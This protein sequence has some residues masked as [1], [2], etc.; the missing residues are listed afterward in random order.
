MDGNNVLT[1]GPGRVT[2]HK[3]YVQG[4]DNQVLTLNN[5]IE[6]AKI[7]ILFCRLAGYSGECSR[8][9]FSTEGLIVFAMDV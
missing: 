9:M 8:Y 5:A 4:T 2:L 7:I 6:P 1:A 3:G